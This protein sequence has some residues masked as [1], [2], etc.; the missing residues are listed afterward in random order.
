MTTI[1]CI[2][3][4]HLGYRHRMKLQRLR[5]YENAFR[6]AIG[7][8]M[9]LKPAIIIF[10]GDLFHHTRPD[11]KSM[12]IVIQNFMKIA[13]STNIVLCIGNHE[14]EGHLGTA[15]TPLF[16]EIHKNIYV[17][18]TEM[19]HIK[20]KINNKTI[21]IHGFQYIRDRK[22]AEEWLERISNE[23]G[24]N[25]VNIL[26]IHQGIERYL[27]PF[28]ISLQSLR[29]VAQKYSLMLIGH[30]HKHQRI[31]E[32]FDVTPAYCIGSTERI[33]FNEWKN[34]NGFLVFRNLEFRNPEFIRLNSAEM[35]QVSENIGKKTPEEIN[36]YIEKIIRKNSNKKC[37]QINIDANVEGDYLD[38]LHDWEERYNEFEILDVNVAPKI[39]S[40][41]IRIEKL[42]IDK[43][44]IKEYFEK[45]GMKNRTELL[46]LCEKLFERYG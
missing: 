30:S 44:V 31:E 14:I 5:D 45:S 23:T 35:V 34:E 43:G 42:Q 3:D 4:C 25:D 16:S 46:E 21:G 20:L 1:C 10:C 40:E 12:Q 36:F 8:A 32:I 22:F 11:P 2:S 37:L 6:E 27:D 38:I 26:C 17:L 24:N 29:N 28:E 39:N 15:Y 19:S 9:E 41:E 13:E 7:K 33:S 18:T